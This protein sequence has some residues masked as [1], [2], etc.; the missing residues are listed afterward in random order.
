MVRGTK[1]QSKKT[2]HLNFRLPLS[3]LMAPELLQLLELLNS[4][5]DS[6]VIFGFLEPGWNP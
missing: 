6:G 5:I 3:W 2:S 1:L 4:S